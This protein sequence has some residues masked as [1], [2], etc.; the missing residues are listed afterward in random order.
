MNLAQAIFG[1]R[2]E[3]LAISLDLGEQYKVIAGI[4][5]PKTFW[6]RLARELA[7]QAVIDD[8]QKKFDTIREY[9]WGKKKGDGDEV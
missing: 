3:D 9:N 2:I 6:R 1:W 5:V 7:A 4:I 8:I